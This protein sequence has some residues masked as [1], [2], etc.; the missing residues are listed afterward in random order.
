MCPLAYQ[1]HYRAS[2]QAA[3]P[4]Q[5]FGEL[6]LSQDGSRCLLKDL[7]KT[8]DAIPHC[9]PCPRIGN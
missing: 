7:A 6:Q 2:A 8:R 9:S 4:E 3:L 1:L 5:C